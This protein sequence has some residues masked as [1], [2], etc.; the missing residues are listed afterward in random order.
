MNR[1]VGS[2]DRIARLIIAILF[3]VANVAGWVMGIAGLALA[4]I[5]GMLLSS[6]ISGHCPL[7]VMLGIKKTI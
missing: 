2:I 1:N 6:V 3:I 5:A 4:V 7:Y